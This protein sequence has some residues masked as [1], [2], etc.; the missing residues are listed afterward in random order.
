[1][2]LSVSDFMQLEGGGME[3]AVAWDGAAW[4][5][6][7]GAAS[8]AA[9]SAAARGAHGVLHASPPLSATAADEDLRAG[10]HAPSSS[11][12]SCPNRNPGFNS[13]P[14]PN[15]NPSPNPDPDQARTVGA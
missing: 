9:A 10:T 2:L 13:R 6:L 7:P 14:N 1:M 5:E 12:H 3:C 15:P 4:R 11:P 8:T